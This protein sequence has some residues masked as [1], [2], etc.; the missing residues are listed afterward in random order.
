MSHPIFPARVS[1][2]KIK[3]KSK[4]K[5]SSTRW[6]SRQLNDPYVRQAKSSGY[7]SR[8]AFKLI[9][10]DK[11]FSFL[12]RG[13]RVVD[14]GA[15]PGGWTQVVLEKVGKTGK[16]VAVDIREF[17]EIDGA[18]CLKMDFT[19]YKSSGLIKNA[20][21]GRA[22][23]I[24]SDMALPVTGHSKTDHLRIMSLAESVW[25]F[26]LQTLAPD[27]VFLCKIF[28]GGTETDLLKKIKSNFKSI[29]H[30]KPPASRKDSSEM[31]LF[32]GGFRS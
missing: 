5:Q 1:R 7:R 9:E 19:D 23:V 18:I 14:L 16:V 29:K 13:Q 10:M 22:N 25:D 6:L 12:K 17:D 15:A 30:I 3:K 4:R 11:K 27:G 28:Q 8:S 24:L 31:Y 21:G 26:A 20:I 2:T 32:V